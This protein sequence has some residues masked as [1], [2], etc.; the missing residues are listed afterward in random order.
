MS[1]HQLAA[2]AGVARTTAKR[3]V[4]S[5][6]EAGFVKV[7]ATFRPG[8]AGDAEESAWR[9]FNEFSLLLW[10][11]TLDLQD[12]GRGSESDRVGGRNPTGGQSESDRGS[13][14]IRPG[15]SRNPTGKE[16]EEEKKKT[17]GRRKEGVNR[18]RDDSAK[19]NRAEELAMTFWRAS[20]ID[21]AA[22]TG[23]PRS[24]ALRV[25]RDDVGEAVSA[26][27]VAGFV[28]FLQSDDWYSQPGRL[29]PGAVAKQLPDWVARGRPTVKVGAPAKPKRGNGYSAQELRESALKELGRNYSPTE[30]FQMAAEERERAQAAAA[31]T[32]AEVHDGEVIDADWSEHV[33]F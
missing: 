4:R 5:L 17:R 8:K 11:E 30:L 6:Q 7:R 24:D 9:G 16:E 27:D 18:A 2:D 10:P 33:Q 23:R 22:V 31:A 28:R 25:F 14:G 32:Q 21:P 12:V 1:L 3:A 26:D 19:S 15:V 13:V 20:G 29:T